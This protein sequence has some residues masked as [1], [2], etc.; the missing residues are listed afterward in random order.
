MLYKFSEEG[1]PVNEDI[2]KE[3]VSILDVL[4]QVGFYGTLL[5]TENG[6]VGE[7]PNTE[8]P[9]TPFSFPFQINA[10]GKRFSCKACKQKG[11]VIDFVA[12]GMRGDRKKALCWLRETAQQS[13]ILCLVSMADPEEL[14]PYYPWWLQALVAV[15]VGMVALHFVMPF[16]K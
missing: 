7:C 16:L 11:D 4:T 9:S 1:V 5:Q 6:W 13:M 8:C 10:E 3:R 15:S 14:P 12:L 2:I